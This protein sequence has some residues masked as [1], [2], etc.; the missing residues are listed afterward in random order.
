MSTGTAGHDQ[1]HVE[2]CGGQR[3]NGSLFCARFPKSCKVI[4]HGDAQPS[5]HRLLTIMSEIVQKIKL[6][7]IAHIYY[8][9]EDTEQANKFLHDFGI[10]MFLGYK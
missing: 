9:H 3:S 2:A 4:S 1:L 7:R 5:S 6:K 10:L 8:I